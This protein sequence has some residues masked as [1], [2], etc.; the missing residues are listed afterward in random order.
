MLTRQSFAAN[1]KPIALTVGNQH[2]LLDPREFSTGSVGWF[3][4]G[5]I[6]LQ[7]G[8]EYVKCQIGFNLTVVGSKELPHGEPVATAVPG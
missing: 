6:T 5:K 7:V 2:L 8:D 3:A 4:N 1:A